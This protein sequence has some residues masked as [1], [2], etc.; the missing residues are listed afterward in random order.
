MLYTYIDAI[1]I[2]NILMA[3]DIMI[4]CVWHPIVMINNNGLEGSQSQLC[5]MLKNGTMDIFL[6]L[7]E[8]YHQ[9]L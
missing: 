4:P 1:K 6:A 8:S 2:S 3:A 5:N 7:I 9:I